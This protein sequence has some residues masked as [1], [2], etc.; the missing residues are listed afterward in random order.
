MANRNQT[1]EQIARDK[2]DALLEESG[3][4]IQSAK[5]V[6]FHAGLGIAVREY[7]TDVGPADYVLYS[8]R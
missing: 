1:P 8:F 5:K 2:I 6:D 3:W 4:V 7:T